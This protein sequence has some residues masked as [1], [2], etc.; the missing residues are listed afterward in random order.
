MHIFRPIRDHRYFFIYVP[1]FIPGYTDID[2]CASP[3][4]NDCDSNALCTNTDGSYVCRCLRGFK[5][6]GKVCTGKIHVGCL[7]LAQKIRKFRFKGS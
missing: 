5:G 3:E 6:D 1:L 4:S 7:L 2:E